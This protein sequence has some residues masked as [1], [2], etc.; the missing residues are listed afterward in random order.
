M[1][2]DVAF[3]FGG[4]TGEVVLN[5]NNMIITSEIVPINLT[6]FVK[7]IRTSQEHMGLVGVSGH[8]YNNSCDF[9][10]RR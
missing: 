6:I 7:I 1:N 8:L 5:N 3:H 9:L 10:Q 4:Q 2:E